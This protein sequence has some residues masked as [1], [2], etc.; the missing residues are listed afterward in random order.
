MHLKSLQTVSYSRDRV[1]SVEGPLTR[2]AKLATMLSLAIMLTSGACQAKPAK[3]P[4]ANANWYPAS[5][6]LPNGLSYSCSLTPLP[7]QMDGIP[8]KDR[9]YINHVFAMILKCAQAKTIMI[10][11]LTRGSA[12]NAY[13]TY[14]AST[15]SSLKIIRSEPT[16]RGL[17]TFRNQVLQG[18][19]LQLKFFEKAATA[20]EAGTDFNTILKIPE[21]K[22]ASSQLQSAWSQLKSRYTN[23]SPTTEN[24]M[25][26]HL[27]ALD[28]F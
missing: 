16:P 11:K 12:R 17:E 19:I 22:Q 2:T 8:G 9:L 21:G 10:S 7:A 28:V 20:A 3:K 6:A 15:I 27:C 18:L 26:H 25:Y 24:S 14:Y 13:A 4:A 5:I 23:C 1:R